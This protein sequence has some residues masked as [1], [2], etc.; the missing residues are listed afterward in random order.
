MLP[1]DA[2]DIGSL[3]RDETGPR[4]PGCS[5]EPTSWPVDIRGSRVAA[6]TADSSTPP[7]PED[8][9]LHLKSSNAVKRPV[10]QPPSPPRPSPPVMSSGYASSALPHRGPAHRGSPVASNAPPGTFLPGTKVQVGGHRVVIEKYLSEGGFAH[11]YVARIPRDNNKH[12]VAVLKRV[13]VPDKEHLANMRTEVET[14]KKLKGHRHIVTYIDSHASQ[15]NSGGYEVFLLM[16]FCTGGGLIDFMNTRLQHRLTE[17]E[18][19]KIFGD[20]AEGVACMHYLKPP[21]LHR[22]LKVENVLISKSDSGSPMYKLCDFGSTAPP[23]AAARTTEEGRLIEE[24][25]QKHTTMQYRSPEMIDVWRKQPIDEKADIWALGV[26]LYK[27]CYYTT[28]FEEVGQMAILN[29]SFKYPSYPQFSEKL[30]KFIAWMLKEDPRKRPNIYQVVK[31]TCGMRGVQVP[32]KDIYAERTQSE[33]RRNQTIPPQDPAA[34]SSG[35]IGLQKASSQV[36]T[37]RLPDIAPMRRGR[38]TPGAQQA[39]NSAQPSPS[40]AR[41]DPFAALDS[42]NYEVRAGAVDELSKRFPKLDEFSIAHDPSGQFQFDKSPPITSPPAQN[43]ADDHATNALADDFFATSKPQVEAIKSQST[44][45][46]NKKP[47]AAPTAKPKIAEKMREFSQPSPLMH[48]PTPV[49]PQP[50]YKS[51]AVGSSPPPTKPEKPVPNSKPDFKM[52][53]ISKRPIWRVPDHSRSASLPRASDAESVQPK[54]PPAKR[55]TILDT[56]RSKSH[57]STASAKSPTSSRPSLEGHR[58]SQLELDDP[59]I[60]RAHSAQPRQRPSS[61]YVASNLEFLRDQ[62][63]ARKPSVEIRRSMD[64]TR[65]SQSSPRLI[66]VDS[67]DQLADEANIENDLDYL[68]SNEEADSSKRRHS[69][70]GA[71][72]HKKRSSIPSIANAKSMFAGRFGDAFKRFEHNP[73]EE[74][75]TEDQRPRTPDA[76]AYG[77]ASQSLSPIQGSE[78][79]PSRYTDNVSAIDETEDVPPEVRR[80]LE[81]RRLSEEEKRVTEAAAQ[82]RANMSANGSG[83]TSNLSRAST[84]QKR[85]QSLLDEGR[86]S[87]VAP[88]TAEG[89]GKFTDQ[90]E[91][92]NQS[93]PSRPA[94]ANRP[95]APTPTRPP[96][97]DLSVPGL[98]DLRVRPQQPQPFGNSLTHTASAPPGPQ[99]QRVVSRPSAPPKPKVLRTGQWPPTQQEAEPE[100]PTQQAKPT[101]LAALL[102]KDLEG[103]PDYPPQGSSAA[104]SDGHR[105]HATQEI[106]KGYGELDSAQDLEADFS[107]RYPS[108]TGIEMVEREIGSRGVKEV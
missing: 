34:S 47:A 3:A 33:A 85:V 10:R 73:S 9:R 45:Q 97:A 106:R 87:P 76:Y 96:P 79:T 84:I 1:E 42:K 6:P 32:I 101:G 103:V 59:S 108:L 62:E 74:K 83:N 46:L 11:V 81:R 71:S 16:E 50:N 86:R 49:R 13:A 5:L 64:K 8:C 14:M 77:E 58:P 63:A 72:G 17:P 39:G 21:L 43:M 35:S 82:Y 51:T 88:R 30:K 55:P 89:Y 2:N 67:N 22:D 94:S 31:E 36:Q 75:G 53:E 90:S 66:A 107:A 23:R 12:E 60:A 105:S 24:D 100:A 104:V 93:M 4:A 19:L 69:R 65:S 91:S 15:L 98:A 25:V 37:Q 7:T 68:R 80:E 29:A 44:T 41:G 56:F 78:P 92:D 48:Q 61:A 57:T 52:P 95:V 18:I 99:H 70:Q 20:V 40:P 27:L 38:P 26:L 54:Q 28:P 102:A